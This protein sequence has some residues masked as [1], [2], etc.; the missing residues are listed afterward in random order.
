MDCVLKNQDIV[1]HS[2]GGAMRTYT[3]VADAVNAMFL[4]MDKGGDELYN[5]ANENNLISIRDLAQM[6][7]TLVPDSTCKVRFASED[8]K[9]QYLPFKL[10]ILDTGKV[11]ELGWKPVT[12][13]ET[14]FKWTLESF[15]S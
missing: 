3:Y 4:I 7:V 5:V 9:L 6:M 8:A 13:I 14:M 10:A 12:N 2:D 1:L 15:V 11:Q